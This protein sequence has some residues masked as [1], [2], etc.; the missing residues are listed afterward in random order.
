MENQ[1]TSIDELET[2]YNLFDPVEGGFHRYGTQ[3]DWTPPHYEKMLYDNARLL[4][5]YYHLKLILNNPMLV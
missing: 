2:N 3:K 4:K 5:A 1:Y